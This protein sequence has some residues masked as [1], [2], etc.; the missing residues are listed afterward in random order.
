VSGAEAS[1]EVVL[2]WTADYS[3][4]FDAG[5]FGQLENRR[6]DPTR[7]RSHH[8]GLARPRTPEFVQ[9]GSPGHTTE[10]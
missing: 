1:Y 9:S 10:F 2:V 8:A 4:R 6:A 5:Q 7:G 3:Q